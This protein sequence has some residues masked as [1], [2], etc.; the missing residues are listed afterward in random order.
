MRRLIVAQRSLFDRAIYLLLSI[1]KPNKELKAMDK[2]IAANPD[3]VKAVQAD[4]SPG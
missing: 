1:C 3:I 2:I 4:L